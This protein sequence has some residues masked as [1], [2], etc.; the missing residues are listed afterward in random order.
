MND[1]ARSHGR[2]DAPVLTLPCRQVREVVVDC[3]GHTFASVGR[4]RDGSRFVALSQALVSMT[5][6]PLC[7]PERSIVTAGGDVAVRLAAR[8]DQGETPVLARATYGG[9]CWTV[10]GILPRTPGR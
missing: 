1:D 3:D 9:G 7:A 4:D 5:I 2:P 6:L 10:L 8:A